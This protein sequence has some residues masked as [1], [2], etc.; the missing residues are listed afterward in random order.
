MADDFD[1]ELQ[2]RLALIEDPEYVDPA[3]EDLPRR[4]LVLLAVVGALVV[5]LMIAWSYPA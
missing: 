3:R 1:R 4:D 5:V 2:V